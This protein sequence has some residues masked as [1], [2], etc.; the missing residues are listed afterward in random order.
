M[1]G[2]GL[3]PA[4]D[5]LEAFFA[6][7]REP[8]GVRHG[9]M[10]AATLLLLAV[11]RWV[12]IVQV[13]PFLGGR[14]VPGPVKVGLALVFGWFT[15]PALSQM[16]PVPLAMGPLRFSLAALH[17]VAMG[18]LLGFGASLVFFAAGMGG[19]FLDS[20]RGTLTATVLVPQ[21]QVQTSPLGD[22]YL[23]L[24]VVLYL[25][26]GG[27]LFFLS[28]VMDSYRLFPPG[29]A[30]PAAALLHASFLKLAVAMFVLMVKVVAPAVVVVLL[31]DVVLGVANRVASQMDVFFLG[32]ALKPALGLLVAA[33]SLYA[34]AGL[35]RE[36]FVGFH[37]WLSSWLGNG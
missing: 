14:L 12:A 26:A 15:V 4:P 29:G 1:P 34:L 28:A 20:A 31:A 36:A 13:A 6:P 7:L 8:W 18:L 37:G 21:L 9:A 33:V 22:V 23:Q 10:D 32:L 19:Q 2:G 24:F 27:H 35:S 16:L 25:L 30:M 17:E 5:Q 3:L 11:L